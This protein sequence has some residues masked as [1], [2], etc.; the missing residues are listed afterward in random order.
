M[1]QQPLTAQT[2][3]RTASQ[4]QTTTTDPLQGI[5]SNVIDQATTAAGDKGGILGNIIASVTGSLTTTQANLVGTWTY[6]EPA[7]QF[8]DE[9]LLAQAGGGAAATKVEKKLATIYKMAGLE[10]GK[11]KFTFTADGAFTYTIGKRTFN[12]TYTFDKERKTVNMV[13]AG[14]QFN[15]TAYVT[16]SGPQMSL[17]FDSTKVLELLKLASNYTSANSTLGAIGSIVG[18][19]KGM[20]TGFKFQK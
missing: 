11:V 1:M 12:G 13:A 4:Q 17:C 3:N 16:I 8:E 10:A 15:L 9:N 19:F 20:K 14:G 2:N 18:N 7:V 6:T 5:L